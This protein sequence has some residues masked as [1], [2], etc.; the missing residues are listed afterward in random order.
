MRRRYLLIIAVIAALALGAVAGYLYRRWAAP[1]VSERAR[2]AL[3]DLRRGAEKL[4]R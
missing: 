2:D 4:R 1:T 3:E